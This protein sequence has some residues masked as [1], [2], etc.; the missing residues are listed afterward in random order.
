MEL[1]GRKGELG[2]WDVV[3]GWG[4][5]CGEVIGE[6]CGEVGRSVERE[7]GEVGGECGKV[8]FGVWGMGGKE[9]EEIE[10]G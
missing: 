5:G 4:V 6:G 3:G 2:V 8:R 1:G 9:E 10:V 7:V